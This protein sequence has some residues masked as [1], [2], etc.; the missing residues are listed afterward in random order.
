[1]FDEIIIA[2]IGS[3]H[4]GSF[5]NA[6]KLIELA[7]SLGVDCVKFQTHLPEHETTRTAPSPGYFSTED[8]FEYFTRTGFTKDQWKTLKACAAENKLMFVSSPFSREAVDLL[9]EVEISAYKIASGEVTNLPMLEHI[10]STNRPVLLSSGMSAWRDLDI[11][12]EILRPHCNLTVMQCSSVYPCPPSRVGL[13]VIQEM[14]HRYGN[15]TIGFSDHTEGLSAPIA[16]AAVGAKV[17]EKH[18][19]FSKRMYGSDAQNAMEPTEF[20]QMVT[21]VKEVWSMLRNPV[22]KNCNDEYVEMKAV[23]EKSIVAN[24]N[25]KAGHKLRLTDLGF[26][27][28]GTG[29]APKYAMELIGKTLTKDVFRDDLLIWKHFE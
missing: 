23:F 14:K 28:P 9:E 18:L 4:D 19:T 15:L 25:L 13:N 22:E 24:C 29:I 2:E 16:A 26:K 21:C 8:R 10:A 6:M 17:I 20:R 5:G 3:V 11:A 1:M 12:I 7:A 27:K